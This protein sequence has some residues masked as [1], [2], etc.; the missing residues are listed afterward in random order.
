VGAVIYQELKLVGE[1]RTEFERA[2]N[3]RGNARG[4]DGR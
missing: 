1:V 2:A 4:R 3:L